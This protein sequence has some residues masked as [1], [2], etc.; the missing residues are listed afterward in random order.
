MR[1]TDPELPGLGLQRLAPPSGS[2]QR[3]QAKRLLRARRLHIESWLPAAACA[4]SLTL[5]SVV[6]R[7]PSLDA[8]AVRHQLAP[9]GA[10][11]QIEDTQRLVLE[12]RASSAGVYLYVVRGK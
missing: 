11:L 8:E 6:S 7:G 12:A 5:V 1:H 2:M 3:L 4:A 9:R 10:T